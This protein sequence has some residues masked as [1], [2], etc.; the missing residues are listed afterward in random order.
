MDDDY[1]ALRAVPAGGGEAL[2]L[3]A[4]TAVR[5]LHQP[6]GIWDECACTDEQK[7]NDDH[8]EIEDVGRT[9]VKMYDICVACCTENDYQREGCVD[10]HDHGPDKPI[11]PTIGALDR[12]VPAGV[13]AEP[14]TAYIDVLM[15]VLPHPEGEFVETHDDQDR[16]I[17][18]DHGIEWVTTQDEYARLRIPVQAFGPRAAL[19]V[20]AEPTGPC[21]HVIEFEGKRA[22]CGRVGPHLMHSDWIAAAPAVPVEP[23]ELCVKCNITAPGL[24][25]CPRCGGVLS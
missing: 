22:R 13:A 11:C 8:T 17:G 1:D 6:F 9:C 5:A 21:E 12:A 19:G 23:G 20:A 4:M 24:T 16:G 2:D 10:G 3:D 15:T 25:N 7:D 18:R 14:T